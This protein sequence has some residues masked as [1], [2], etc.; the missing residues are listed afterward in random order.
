MVPGR[1]LTRDLVDFDDVAVDGV[2]RELAALVRSGSQ[3][4]RRW[5]NGFA[6]SYALS[7]LVGAALIAAAILTVRVW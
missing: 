2:T 4:L 3:D 7:M 1:R 5:Q 6:R